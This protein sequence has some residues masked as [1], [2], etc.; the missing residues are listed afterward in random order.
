MEE[1]LRL[2]KP[3]ASLKDQYLDMIEEW[4]KVE[5]NLFLGV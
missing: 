1:K 2:I 5:K 3:S 4:K